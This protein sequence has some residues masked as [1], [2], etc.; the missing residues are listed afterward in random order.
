MTTKCH[1]CGR[2]S[3]RVSLGLACFHCGHRRD[4]LRTA[5]LI[6][7]LLLVAL[8]TALFVCI[9]TAEASEPSI[10]HCV[11]KDGA[12]I[13][14]FALP[15][16]KEN[17]LMLRCYTPSSGDIDP[18]EC[19]AEELRFINAEGMRVDM[20]TKSEKRVSIWEMGERLTIIWDGVAYEPCQ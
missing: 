8:I 3:E 10:F 2:H 4:E 13:Y 9:S 1:W 7:W 14:T 11:E 19:D 18:A 15:T 5:G 16:S 17:P 12:K 6:T 20:I